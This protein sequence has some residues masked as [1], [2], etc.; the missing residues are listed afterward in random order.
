MNQIKADIG[1]RL[2]DLIR[3]RKW[4]KMQFAEK[5]GI[6]QTHVNLYLNGEYDPIRLVDILLI[7]GEITESEKN[8]LLTGMGRVF[9]SVEEQIAYESGFEGAKPVY[10]YPVLTEV[11]AGEPADFTKMYFDEFYP[12]PY[13]KNEH[14]C[15]VV[16]VNGKSMETTLEDGDLVLCDM[17][18]PLIDNCL[19][20]VKLANGNQY[21]KRYREVNYAFIQLSSDNPNFDNR[22]ID[23]NDIVAIYRVVQSVRQH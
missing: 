17:D 13:K 11:F 10:E 1:K 6:Y 16:K 9:N 18:A 4:K 3:V 21:I 22:L 20:A 7:K 23:K 5:C 14:R 15:F 2:R 8:W 19:V 12:F